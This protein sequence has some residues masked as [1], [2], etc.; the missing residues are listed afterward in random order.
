MEDSVMILL[1][2]FWIGTSISG[3][4]IKIHTTETW[5][6]QINEHF[7]ILKTKLL[8]SSMSPPSKRAST[9]GI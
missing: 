5:D 3:V 1:P 9:V 4:D 7:L 6:I 2:Y 8:E